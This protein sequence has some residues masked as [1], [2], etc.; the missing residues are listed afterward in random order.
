MIS[1]NALANRLNKHL[2]RD[3]TVNEELKASTNTIQTI[4]EAVPSNE[5]VQTPQPTDSLSDKFIEFLDFGLNVVCFGFAAQF[6]LNA[7][8]PILGTLAVGYTI[9]FILKKILYNFFA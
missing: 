9:N 1:H 4:V 3:T 6:L 2:Y 7:T 5:E 8:W